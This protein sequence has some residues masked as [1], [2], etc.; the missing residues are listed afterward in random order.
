MNMMPVS[1]HHNGRKK[2]DS[3]AEIRILIAGAG[4]GGHLFPGIA[5]AERVA[6]LA[7]SE[8]GAKTRVCFV[9]TGRP[10]EKTVLAQ[11]KYETVQISSAG[12]KGA[13]AYGKLRSLGL[14]AGGIFLSGRILKRY[15]PHAVLGMGGYS[16]A[17]V[18]LAAWLAGI[19]RFIHEQNRIP[20]ITNRFLCRFSDRVYVSF[21]DTKI[22]CAKAKI[23]FSGYPLRPEIREMPDGRREGKTAGSGTDKAPP[24]TVLVLGGSQGARSLNRAMTEAL[25]YVDH[26]GDFAFIHQAGEADEAS[27]RAAYAEKGAKAL[28]SAFFSDMASVYQ[29]ADLA[30]CR[31]GAGTLAELTA[32]R[33][34]A[35]LV[36]YPH[37]ADNH[38]LANARAMADAGGARILMEPDLTPEALA[39]TMRHYRSEPAELEKMRANIAHHLHPGDAAGMIAKDIL[40]LAGFG[41]AAWKETA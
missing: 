20:G 32:A 9:T 2:D 41:P 3:P 4:T 40:A 7:A 13:S 14:L 19:P 6:G 28:V 29:N 25:H 22:P 31:A 15:T 18:V 37:A 27:V 30:F 8:F 34:P 39:D 10:V 26:V 35:I 33:V 24:L 11:Q 12:I 21:P 23:R 36:P 17:P 1:H 38:Q 5:V 16:S